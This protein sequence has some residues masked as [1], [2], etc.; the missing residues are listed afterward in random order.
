M[1]FHEKEMKHSPLHFQS[2]FAIWKTPNFSVFD[3]LNVRGSSLSLWCVFHVPFPQIC[4][5]CNFIPLR[6]FTCFWAILS[7]LITK[8]LRFRNLKSL[9]VAENTRER[10]STKIFVPSFSEFLYI[11]VYLLLHNHLNIKKYVTQILR[12]MPSRE[13][14]ELITNDF[15]FWNG[16]VK[17][18]SSWFVVDSHKK[19]PTSILKKI[20]R[21]RFSKTFQ[22]YRYLK[23]RQ[24]Q[25]PV[26][27][28][29]F[30]LH[31]LWLGHVWKCGS[32]DSLTLTRPSNP[33]EP[34]EPSLLEFPPFTLAV[35]TVG[36][37]RCRPPYTH[38]THVVN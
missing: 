31:R 28:R 13:N 33:P 11:N 36:S 21:D 38:Y 23:Y 25:F 8:T 7:A 26:P 18:F 29:V 10:A 2:S 34:M 15:V 24:S 30:Y 22:K 19:E 9:Q 37:H 4:K 20:I 14:Y 1:H 6:A 16:S 12:L 35:R 5:W 27:R 17:R 3:G 32:H